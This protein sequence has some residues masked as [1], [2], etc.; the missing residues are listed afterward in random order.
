MHYHK[1][2]DYSECL[3]AFLCFTAKWLMWIIKE[4]GQS[5]NGEYF[6]DSVLTGGVFPFLR[7]RD[8]V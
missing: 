3:G 1:V 8:N 4:K 7:D 6:R 2:V 5:W